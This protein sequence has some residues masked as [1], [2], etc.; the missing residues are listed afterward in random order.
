ME[1]TRRPI[2]GLTLLGYS[3]SLRTF[4][5]LALVQVALRLCE[6]D[7]MSELLELASEPRY[8]TS[9]LALAVLTGEKEVCSYV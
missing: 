5:T 1:R 2:A 8:F 7:L 6:L 9:F 3:G 4:L